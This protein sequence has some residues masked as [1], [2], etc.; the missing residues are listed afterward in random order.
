MDDIEHGKELSRR[1]LEMCEE[2]EATGVALLNA[3]G[4]ALVGYFMVTKFQNHKQRLQ[5]VD[6]WCASLREEVSRQRS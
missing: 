6:H 4:N 2:D 3:M 1:F 5:E